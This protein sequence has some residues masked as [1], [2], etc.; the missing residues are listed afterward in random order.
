MKR[1]IKNNEDEEKRKQERFD[2]ECR[3]IVEEKKHPRE[4]MLESISYYRRHHFEK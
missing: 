2:A 3:F 4:R 1:A